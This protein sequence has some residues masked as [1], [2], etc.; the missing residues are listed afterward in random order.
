LRST[1]I[2]PCL[3]VSANITAILVLKKVCRSFRARIRAGCERGWGANEPI[4]LPKIECHH[5]ATQ[6]N[7]G[8]MADGFIKELIES[9]ATPKGAE[10]EGV[11][12]LR[13]P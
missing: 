4:E 11:L 2:L 3:D 7:A 5:H 12:I 1:D 6:P 8:P 9:G 13:F 10:D